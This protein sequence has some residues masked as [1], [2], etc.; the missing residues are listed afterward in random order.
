LRRATRCIRSV[1]REPLI[2]HARC[3]TIGL[4]HTAPYIARVLA[5]IQPH[6]LNTDASCRA[7]E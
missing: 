2:T 7:I 4:P 3:S 1:V 5:L 6:H